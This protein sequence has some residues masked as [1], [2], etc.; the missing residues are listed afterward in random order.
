MIIRVKHLNGKTRTC[1]CGEELLS[2]KGARTVSA[3]KHYR[4]LE[5]LTACES[6]KAEYRVRGGKI[7]DVEVVVI[8]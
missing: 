2:L 7:K 8:E 3:G 6:C 4:Q 5:L 1:D